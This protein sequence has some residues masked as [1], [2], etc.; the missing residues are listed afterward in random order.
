M[1]LLPWAPLSMTV[2]TDWGSDPDMGFLSLR[3]TSRFAPL[4]G[5]DRLGIRRALP[6][7]GLDERAC[8]RRWRRRDCAEAGLRS[9]SAGLG[10]HLGATVPKTTTEDRHLSVGVSAD[11]TGGR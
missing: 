7:F 11:V 3:V 2:S 9:R 8:A 4:L 10:P 5:A 6:D 1:V